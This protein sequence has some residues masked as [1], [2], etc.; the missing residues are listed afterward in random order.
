M[1][2]DKHPPLLDYIWDRTSLAA[3]AQQYFSMM[4]Q[5]RLPRV[6][7]IFQLDD[8]ETFRTWHRKCP[9]KGLLLRRMILLATG[10]VRRRLVLVAEDLSLA[11]FALG[12]NRRPHEHQHIAERVV[13]LKDNLCCAR[14]GLLR[15]L[16]KSEL[17]TQGLIERGPHF[18]NVANIAW[19]SVGCVEK[20]HARHRSQSHRQMQWHTFAAAQVNAEAKELFETRRSE[21]AKQQQRLQ[22]RQPTQATSTRPTQQPQQQTAY[23]LRAQ[24]AEQIYRTR[25]LATERA[26]GRRHNPCSMDIWAAARHAWA[27]ENPRVREATILEATTSRHLARMS[28]N[29]KRNHIAIVDDRWEPP[30][31]LGDISSEA[32]QA[33]THTP[34]LNDSRL[35][36]SGETQACG[37]IDAFRVL[38]NDKTTQPA[39]LSASVLEHFL[40]GSLFVPNLQGPQMPRTLRRLEKAWKEASARIAA[41]R[42]FPNA[43]EYQTHCGALCQS[44]T[45]ARTLETPKKLLGAWNGLT[46]R[47]SPNGQARESC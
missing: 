17:S 30:S 43:V 37:S 47:L 33:R 11:L 21:E 24:S 13:N 18:Y 1:S 31:A 10:W 4:L 27:N 35:M 8:V 36:A 15:R 3:Q 19:L 29:A 16:C 20:V 46:K 5:G 12:D 2:H 23:P 32:G 45:S 6:R 40:A 44:S 7:L 42:P 28:R 39:P 9:E 38:A 34:S 25:W 14:P 26:M 22:L 41:G